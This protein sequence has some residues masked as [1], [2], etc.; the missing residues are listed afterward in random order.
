VAYG[1]GIDI[2]NSDLG[3]ASL[4]SRVDA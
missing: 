1:G 3:E 2:G 4:R